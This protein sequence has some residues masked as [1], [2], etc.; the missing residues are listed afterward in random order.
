MSIV[1]K[2][3]VKTIWV[4]FESLWMFV[5]V[6]MGNIVNSFS[7]Q[8]Q[9]RLSSRCLS[10]CCQQ[11]EVRWSGQAGKHPDPMVLAPHFQQAQPLGRPLRQSGLGWLLLNDRDQ[12]WANGQAGSGFA[13]GAGSSGVCPRVRQISRLSG[14]FPSLRNYP[15]QAQTGKVFSCWRHN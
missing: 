3:V 8:S 2:I 13:P 9:E 6:V 11:E 4:Y 10:L 14:W 12:P 7:G 5:I 15:G 1:C